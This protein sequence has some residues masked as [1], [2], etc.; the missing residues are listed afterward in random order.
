MLYVSNASAEG[1]SGLHLK[2]C[3]P[4][5]PFRLDIPIL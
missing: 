3:C 2:K 4:R 1:A 5:T